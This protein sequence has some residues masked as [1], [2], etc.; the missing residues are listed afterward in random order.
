M[1]F[2]TN[3]K[4]SS[5][6]DGFTL[7]ELLV[8]TV[9]VGILGSIAAPGW[10]SF[11]TRQKINSVKSDLSNAIREVQA[12]T[13]QRSSQ[14]RTITFKNTS[15][16]PVVDIGVAGG[17]YTQI[18]GSNSKNIKINSFVS[19][20]AGTSARDNINVNQK[21]EFESEY[22]P[23]VIK[24]ESTDTSVTKCLIITTLLGGL[25]EADGTI[26]DNPLPEN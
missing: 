13:Q 8:V 15:E 2:F 23:F 21:G 1:I 24:I 3:R 12:D 26:C 25:A 9:I 6:E 7:V 19:S 14:S 10:L 17:A 4:C 16:G 5:T 22:V 20:T 11:L 18:L